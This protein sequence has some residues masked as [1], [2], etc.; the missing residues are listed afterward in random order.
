MLILLAALSIDPNSVTYRLDAVCIKVKP[1]PCRNN[2]IKNIG[3]DSVYGC[4]YKDQRASLLSN[5]NPIN[6]P[7]INDN[8]L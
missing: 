6:I 5:L 8:S 3:K 4:W 2:P 7:L 1:A